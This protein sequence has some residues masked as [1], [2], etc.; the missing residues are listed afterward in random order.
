MRLFREHLAARAASAAPTGRD[1]PEVGAALGAGCGVTPELG[2]PDTPFWG[3]F[4]PFLKSFF[5]SFFHSYFH[6]FKIIIIYLFPARQATRVPPD[7]LASL[8]PLP[9]LPAL[10]AAPP[11]RPPPPACFPHAAP[12]PFGPGPSAPRPEP[13]SPVGGDGSRCSSRCGSRCRSR[14]GS[15]RTPDSTGPRRACGPFKQLRRQAA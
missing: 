12:Q 13:R 7:A 3:V 11:P 9:A 8:E 14:C 6:F 10:P 5:F 15:A 1:A 2:H 4:H